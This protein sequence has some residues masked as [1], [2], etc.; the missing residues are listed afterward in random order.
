MSA[1]LDT[2]AKFPITVERGDGA[3]IYNQDGVKYL[4]LYG[5]HAVS[6]LGHSPKNLAQAIA[7][8]AE[9]LL[10]YSNVVDLEI[11][12]QAAQALIDFYGSPTAK[13][14]F[15]NSGAEANEN[16]LKLALQLTGRSKFIAFKG[17]FHGRTFL[18]SRVTDHPEWHTQTGAWTGPVEFIAVNDFSS[19]EKIDASTAAVILEPIQSMAGV[20]EFSSEYL[21]A[22]R[23]K[24]LNV[25]SLL[26]FDE[27]QTGMGR[28]GI[29][30]ISGANG[31]WPD[32]TTL[33]KGIAGGVPLGALIASGEISAKIKIGD[34]GSTFGA[35]P[36][37]MAALLETAS[38]IVKEDLSAKARAFE[39]SIKKLLSAPLVQEVLG[40]GCLLGIRLACPAKE[41]QK[42]L[43]EKKIITGTSANPQ[44][45]RL[46]PPLIATESH[47]KEFASALASIGEKL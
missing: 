47:A 14:F 23:E 31:I 36:L 2:Y 39:L 44:V 30:F 28:T 42:A 46:M 38:T 11:R 33:A 24:T 43:L 35:G 9:K 29:P 5:G 18:A 4:D 25:G 27:V 19:L 3:Y 8:Q 12:E 34:L 22:L 41:I 15:C 6:V 1:L 21:K 10:F 37:A 17:S 40:H 7:K 32:F 26:I 13:V 20:V 45:L 16:A